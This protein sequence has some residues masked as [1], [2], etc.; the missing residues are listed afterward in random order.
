MLVISRKVGESVIIADSIRVTIISASNDKITM[1]IEA[2]KDVQIIR[3][4]LFETIAANQASAGKIDP[5]NVQDLA[6]LL[7][8]QNNE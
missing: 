2:P 8:K 5:A 6:G 3:S 4:E 7:K 1:G